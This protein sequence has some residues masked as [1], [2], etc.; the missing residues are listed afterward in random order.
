ASVDEVLAI[1]VENTV[2]RPAFFALLLCFLHDS[3]AREG[4]DELIGRVVATHPTTCSYVRHLVV[5]NFVFL[6]LVFPSVEMDE[7]RHIIVHPSIQRPM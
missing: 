4:R 7:I 2:L 3:R 5:L 6:L 1:I